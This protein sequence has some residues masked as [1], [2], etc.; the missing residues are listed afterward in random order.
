MDTIAVLVRGHDNEPTRMEARVTVPGRVE[1]SRNEFRHSLN[2]PES[3]VYR[4]DESL[5]RQL[6]QAYEKGDKQQ[7]SKLWDS[8]QRLASDW[9]QQETKTGE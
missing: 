4:F 9:I 8:A 3:I 2:V 6:K 7:L 1:V 5:E